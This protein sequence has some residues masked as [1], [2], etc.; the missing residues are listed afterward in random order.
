MAS[1]SYT[2]LF[3]F[4]WQLNKQQKLHLIHAQACHVNTPASNNEQ[5]KKLYFYK[6][7]TSAHE[8]TIRLENPMNKIRIKDMHH[9]LHF[10]SP[11]EILYIV[12]AYK[13]Q[14]PQA[15][16]HRFHQKFP[17]RHVHQNL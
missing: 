10:L 1:V 7:G 15:S 3:T 17:P 4:I 14:L 2:H 9:Q 8:D 16:I 11:M 5:K 6:N 12:D 13:R